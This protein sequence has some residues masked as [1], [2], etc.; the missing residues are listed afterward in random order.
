MIEFTQL[1]CTSEAGEQKTGVINDEC[2]VAVYMY[3]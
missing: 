2:Y 1:M 3:M